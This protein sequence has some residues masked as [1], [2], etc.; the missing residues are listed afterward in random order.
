MP[1][2]AARPIRLA[3]ALAL[4]AFIP[5]AAQAQSADT[6]PSRPVRLVIPFAPGGPT[7]IAG[8]VIG[9]KVAP[10]LGQPMIVDNRPGAGGN[11]GA[12]IVARSAPDGYTVVMGVTGSH[13]INLALQKS[14]PYHPLKDFEPVT[15]AT[16]F[17]NA[18]AVHPDVPAQSLSE[19][20]ALAKREP[21][22]LSYGTDGVGTA[23]HLTMELL[24]SKAAMNLV[25]VPYKGAAPMLTELVGGQIQVGI[26]GLPAMQAQAKAGKIRIL[27]VTTPER[28]ASNPEIPTV[29][30][31][32]FPGFSAAP[33]AG[34]F[35]PRGTPLPIVD[36]LAAALI[37]AMQ[38]PEVR[39][40]MADLGSTVV[41]SQPTEF[42]R[43]VES[44]IEKW[45]DAVKAAGV[46][47]Q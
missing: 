31:Q 3:A 19:L 15:Q 7:D 11:V 39:Q 2:I 4:A 47:P 33:W 26:T 20:V 36:K 17:P 29:S 45:A 1:R 10:L 34:F 18:I 22:K 35:V 8:R 16:Q 14:L 38:M 21:G 25:S 46:Q 32:G 42:R 37:K 28:V 41:A 44:E 12:E 5:M 43:F 23:S 9:E 40:K 6:Y 24:K 13:A 27:A 30:E